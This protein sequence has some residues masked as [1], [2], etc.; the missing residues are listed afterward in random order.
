ML[1]VIQSDVS[2]LCDGL[3]CRNANGHILKVRVAWEFAE[4]QWLVES[5]L[6]GVREADSWCLCAV[7][8]KA[9]HRKGT[10]LCEAGGGASVG[11]EAV[12]EAGKVKGRDA[13]ASHELSVS[14][15]G[16]VAQLEKVDGTGSASLLRGGVGYNRSCSRDRLLVSTSQ[17]ANRSKENVS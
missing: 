16:E 5:C 12:P 8:V 17:R 3:A 7:G 13:W 1:H 15:Q 14:I 10:A 2:P 11:A 9:D 4:P 6:G